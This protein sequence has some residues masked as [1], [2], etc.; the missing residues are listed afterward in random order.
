MV[1][2][3]LENVR[4]MSSEIFTVKYRP[5]GKE[6]FRGVIFHVGMFRRM[7]EGIVRGEYSYPRER[8]HVSVCHSY[9][10]GHPG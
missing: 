10:L 4:R 1:I 2:F 5:F 7:S 3:K 9:D 8:L 6:K